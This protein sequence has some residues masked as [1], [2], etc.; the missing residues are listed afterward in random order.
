MNLL[1]HAF[2]DVL[3]GLSLAELLDSVL[4]VANEVDSLISMKVKDSL[5]P[6]RK[7]ISSSLEM[8][9]MLLESTRVRLWDI[10]GAAAVEES[11]G[12]LGD[13]FS[14]FMVRRNLKIS[15]VKD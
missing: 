7:L 14:C 8:S 5:L 9:K 10:S 13:W 15:E 1:T 11:E 12:S 4:E 6:A 2:L 3:L